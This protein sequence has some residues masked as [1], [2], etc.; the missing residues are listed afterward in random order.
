MYEFTYRGKYTTQLLFNL[1]QVE[2]KESLLGDDDD[3]DEARYC[4]GREVT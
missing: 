2:F 3:K 1:Q 4:K